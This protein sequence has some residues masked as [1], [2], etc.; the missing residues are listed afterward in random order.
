MYVCVSV[1]HEH[2]KR[3]II[4]LPASN[5]KKLLT[6][7]SLVLSQKTTFFHFLEGYISETAWLTSQKICTD[8]VLGIIC[9]CAKFNRKQRGD[10]AHKPLVDLTRND[11]I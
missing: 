11:P 6:F 3:A 7:D 9:K 10:C 4:E 1:T 8:F 2:C 5:R